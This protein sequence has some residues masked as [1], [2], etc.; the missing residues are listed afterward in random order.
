MNKIIRYVSITLISLLIVYLL[1]TNPILKEVIKTAFIAFVLAYVL[2]PVQGKM[3]EKGIGKKISSIILLMAVLLMIVL[4][5]AFLI[6]N[7][8]KETLTLDHTFDE[9]QNFIENIN[10]TIESLSNN[11]YLKN[12]INMLLKKGENLASNFFNNLVDGIFEKTSNVFSLAVIPILIYYILADG[13]VLSKSLIF[14]IPLRKRCIIRK[15]GKN[16]NIALSKYILSQLLLCALISIMTFFVLLILDIGFPIML[17]LL[18]GIFNIVPYFGPLLGSLPAVIIALLDSPK[19]A[20]WS[21]L[22]L[23]LIQQIEGD[24]IAPKITGDTVDIHPLFI[25]LLLI[26]GGK[27]GGFIGMVMAVPIAVIAKVIVEDLDYYMYS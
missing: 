7:I 2:K 22:F 18:N 6:P 1:Y 23:N 25:I 20:I 5:F 11:R 26:A 9:M 16:I 10:K 27:V 14:L 8:I 19:K 12:A 4:L 21:I 3:M 13:D 17:S 15:L 24:I